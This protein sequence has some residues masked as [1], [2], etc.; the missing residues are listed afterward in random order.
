MEIFV[1][2]ATSIGQKKLK[3]ATS[4]GQNKLRIRNCP[5]LQQA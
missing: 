2:S 5:L 4:I 1:Q 3:I